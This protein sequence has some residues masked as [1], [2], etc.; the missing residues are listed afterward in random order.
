MPH[1]AVVLELARTCGLHKY[2]KRASYELL[3]T[4]TFW[5]A[6]V[7]APAAHV[8]VQENPRADAEIGL[9]ELPRADLL[10]LL[11]T[12]EQLI[13]AWAKIAGRAP[14][15]FVCPRGTQTQSGGGSSTSNSSHSGCASA[16]DSIDL[17]WVMMLSSPN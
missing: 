7:A 2:Q 11:H 1:A 6:I 3:R 14:T 10:R 15:D 17:H 5:Q 4:P 9:D 16:S 12:R 8:E 13:L